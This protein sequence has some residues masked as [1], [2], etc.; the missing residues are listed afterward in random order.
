MATHSNILAWRI[1]G[2][3]EPGG[4]LYVGSHRVGYNRSDLAAA[5]A[6]RFKFQG[7]SLAGAPMKGGS[8]WNLLAESWGEE[9]ACSQEAFLKNYMYF[10]LVCCFFYWLI[11]IFNLYLTRSIEIWNAFIY[12]KKYNILLIL[13]YCSFWISTLLGCKVLGYN[14][15]TVIYSW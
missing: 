4:L 7:P 15:L 12:G 3:E 10:E 8:C 14:Y 1:P 5:A 11:T 13:L 9:A 6:M 2:T